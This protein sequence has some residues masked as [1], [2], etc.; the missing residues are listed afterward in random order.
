MKRKTQSIK[1][2]PILWYIF[3]LMILSQTPWMKAVVFLAIP[4]FIHLVLHRK[5]RDSSASNKIILL[6]L[7]VFIGFASGL[8]HLLEYDLYYFGR[9]IMYF[10]QAPIFILMGIYLCENTDDYKVLIKLIVITS[11]LVTVYK[12]IELAINPSLLFKL[13][14]DTRYEYDL[15]NPTALLAFII[16][17]YARK[18]K[19]KLFKNFIE[20]LIMSISLFS[21]MISFSRTF[22]ILLLVLIIIPYVNNYKLF[23]KM[24]WITAFCA[25]FIIFGCLFINVKTDASQGSTFQSKMSHSLDEIIVK[26]YETSFEITQNWRGYEAFLG[27]SKFYEG[28]GFEILFGQ[29][30]G[31]VV[32]TPG[33]I[34]GGEDNN[35]GIL[36]MFHNGFI[37]IL[38]KTG[39]LGL[40]IFFLF[41]FKVLQTV[42]KVVLKTLKKQKQFTALLLLSAVFT[43]LFQTFVVHGIFTTSIPFSLIVLTGASIKR[44]YKKIDY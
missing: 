18:L 14:L 27:L 31:T 36:P 43:I 42:P 41:V 11:I 13:G 30:F 44:L 20:W 23:L 7:I 1:N 24:Y 33:W 15:S 34:F 37:T 8:F 12:L 29:G 38:L 25:L 26:D 35:L 5:K 40:L 2:R 16:L 10:I 19:I 22:Y 3:F 32:Y 28:N 9:D 6:N 4:L 17:F 39:L 21:V